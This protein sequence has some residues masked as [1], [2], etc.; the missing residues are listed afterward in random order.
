MR[1]K[2]SYTKLKLNKSKIGNLNLLI[3]GGG[4]F[5]QQEDDTFT[6][7]TWDCDSFQCYSKVT[8]NSLEITCTG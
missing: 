1:K 7:G 2:Y 8:C 6:Q 3:K 4:N 5:T